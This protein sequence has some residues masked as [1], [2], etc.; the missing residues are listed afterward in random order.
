MKPT[1]F[2]PVLLGICLSCQDLV[3]S[4]NSK[5]NWPS[6][7]GDKAVSHYSELN[8]ITKANVHRLQVAWVYDGGKLGEN[9][10]TQIQCNPLI[11]D[12][13]MYGT[14]ADLKLFALNAT[15]GKEIRR[16]AQHAQH[17]NMHSGP[18]LPSVPTA[19]GRPS[20]PPHGIHPSPRH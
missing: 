11:I 6:Y 14:T 2:F 1:T 15:T 13:V 20:G 8:Q 5:E 10:R 17:P 16:T 9:S 18:P 7:L 19:H 4:N 3:D 12:G